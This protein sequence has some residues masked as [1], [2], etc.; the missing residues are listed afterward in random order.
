MV[1]GMTS[2][3]T[4]PPL[5]TIA[6]SSGL[7]H[8]TDMGMP[9]SAVTSARLCSA[10]TWFAVVSSGTPDCHIGSISALGSRAFREFFSCRLEL[11]ARSR[12]SLAARVLSSRAA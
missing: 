12:C 4:T 10:V 11:A 7:A 1:L 6:S 9:F 2:L 3:V 5:V 8:A